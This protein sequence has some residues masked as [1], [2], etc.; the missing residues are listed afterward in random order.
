MLLISHDGTYLGSGRAVCVYSASAGAERGIPKS[1]NHH[2][3]ILSEVAGRC[4]SQRSVRLYFELCYFEAPDLSS[5][6]SNYK[7]QKA[8]RPTAWL[9]LSR[10]R[11]R[12]K[13]PRA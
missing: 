3:D 2:L 12:L 4:A 11:K 13:I 9:Y 1:W 8:L 10:Q 7:V 5:D 6:H